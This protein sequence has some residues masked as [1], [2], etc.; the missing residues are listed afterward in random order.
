[1]VKQVQYG[2]PSMRDDVETF[3]GDSPYPVSLRQI[4]KGISCSRKTAIKHT[5]D[6][7][8]EG[9]VTRKEDAT[10]TYLYWSSSK[11]LTVRDNP[12]QQPSEVLLKIKQLSERLSTEKWTPVV[13]KGYHVY[14][15]VLASL[16]H[17]AADQLKGMPSD[18]LQLDHL[19]TK[20]SE[21]YKYVKNLEKMLNGMLT[22]PDLWDRKNLGKFISDLRLSPEDLEER[23]EAIRHYN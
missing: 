14:P 8:N 11:N 10:G 1:M 7:I 13:A 2:R 17:E 23:S 9:T 21:Y 19:K 3:I 4:C 6:L 5:T 12:T 15:E 16:L 22:L 18:Q 20:L